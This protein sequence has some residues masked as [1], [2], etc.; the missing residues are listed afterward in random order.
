MTRRRAIRPSLVALLCL[1]LGAATT[2]GV[3]WTLARHIHVLAWQSVAESATQYFEEND[4]ATAGW[5]V[6]VPADWPPPSRLSATRRTGWLREIASA[7]EPPERHV[8]F[9]QSF[10][11]PMLSLQHQLT[12]R[13]ERDARAAAHPGWSFVSWR[14]GLW[15]YDPAAPIPWLRHWQLP[16]NPLWPGF[17]I[18]TALYATSWWALLFTPLPLYRTARRRLRVSRGTCGACGYDLKGS[19][20][21]ACPECGHAAGAKA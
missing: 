21:R 20:G 16:L 14:I 6:P 17:A 10:G 12:G 19:P 5:P 11:W 1:L 15:R 9:V 4:A 18:D 8:L 2:V 13:E 7:G 3:A